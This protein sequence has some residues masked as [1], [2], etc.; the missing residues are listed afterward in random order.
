[1]RYPLISELFQL[2]RK[3]QLQSSIVSHPSLRF[4]STSTV[5]P[6]KL[7]KKQ[8]DLLLEQKS[9]LELQSSTKPQQS[10]SNSASKDSICLSDL[11]PKP[12][13]T[14]GREITPRAKWLRNWGSI[15]TCSDGC[16]S[17]KPGR[18]NTI[19][20]M[21]RRFTREEFS[22]INAMIERFRISNL[23]VRILEEKGME[24]SKAEEKTE[25][26]VELQLDLEAWV[27]AVLLKLVDRSLPET[28]STQ[29]KLDKT[30]S[31][32]QDKSKE[33]ESS[34]PTSSLVSCS[35]VEEQLTYQLDKLF[36]DGLKKPSQQT[37]SEKNDDGTI[38]RSQSDRSITVDSGGRQRSDPSGRDSPTPP[39]QE[40]ADSSTTNPFTQA[41]NSAP[42]LRERVRRAA[43]RLLIFDRDSEWS[44]S[45]SAPTLPIL[46]NRKISLIN[47]GQKLKSLKDVSFAKGE[48]Y[49][50]LVDR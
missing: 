33:K 24:S 14:C 30:R 15:S 8:R 26:E 49:L 2:F 29:S 5:M 32:S 50:R 17:Q 22:D 11:S 7:S 13:L 16:R 35:Q 43:R 23:Q 37:P 40:Q 18:R 42:G 34:R 41:L 3:K 9:E 28:P 20:K 10:S 21:E 19:I 36:P 44:N 31:S 39:K 46:L 45:P 38:E 25:L 4:K 48:I 27:E 12:C 6:P 47:N 1:M